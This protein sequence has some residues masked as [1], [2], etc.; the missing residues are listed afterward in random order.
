MRKPRPYTADLLKRGSGSNEV[1][2]RRRWTALLTFFSIDIS[3]EHW[4]Y[5]LA[6]SLCKR[7]YPETFSGE[8]VRLSDIARAISYLPTSPLGIALCLAV[9]F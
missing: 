5:D 3:R 4:D 9:R 8:R 1:A 7:H 2:F 6:L